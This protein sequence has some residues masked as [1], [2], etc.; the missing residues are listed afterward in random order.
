M[1]N[2]YLQNSTVFAIFGNTLR[3]K[4]MS[5]Q[6]TIQP[7]CLRIAILLT[8]Y[9]LHC[10]SVMCLAAAPR[11]VLTAVNNQQANKHG[12]TKKKPYSHFIASHLVIKVK[13]IDEKKIPVSVDFQKPDHSFSSEIGNCALIPINS[14]PPDNGCKRYCW[15]RVLLI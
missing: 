11:D 12:N 1:L 2:F 6:K 4:T 3:H 15:C 13:Q 10:S 14:C 5:Y 9:I 7:S 8:L